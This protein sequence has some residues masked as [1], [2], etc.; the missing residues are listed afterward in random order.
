MKY[1][2]GGRTGPEP[3]KLVT[4]P[5]PVRNTAVFII[6]YVPAG[7]APGKKRSTMEKMR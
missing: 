4:V 3:R 5:L 1:E 7:G 6:P 2:M